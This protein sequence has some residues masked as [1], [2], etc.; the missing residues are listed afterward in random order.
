MEKVTLYGIDNN[1]G[2]GALRIVSAKADER[3]KTYR[4][5]PDSTGPFLNY[6][7]VIAKGSFLVSLTPE[8]AIRRYI[9]RQAQDIQ[10]GQ[11]AAALK[12]EAEELLAAIS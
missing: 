7:L 5:N 10:R 2:R 8:A 12:A 3:K 11:R 4:L 6:R 1:W 9:N